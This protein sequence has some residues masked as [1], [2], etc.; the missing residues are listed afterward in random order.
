[1]A[2]GLNNGNTQIYDIET[3]RLIRTLTGHTQRV[4]SCAYTLGPI[5]TGSRDRS[6]QCH[7]PRAPHPRTHKFQGHRGEVC[8]IKNDPCGLASG[9][10][11]DLAIVW[12][13]NMGR[14]RFV[15]QGHKGAVK[16]LEWCGWQRNLLVTGG[17]TSDKT[18][19][20]WNI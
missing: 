5:Y 15:L 1:M 14:S 9:S 3:Q 7:D 18:M 6:I 17:G 2:V 4:S 13:V 10:N 11:D 20:M 12:D 8:G 19:R 16:A